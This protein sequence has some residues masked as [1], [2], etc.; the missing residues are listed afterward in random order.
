MNTGREMI[1]VTTKAWA[2]SM[3][4]EEYRALLNRLL[5]AERAGAKLL[6]AYL[7][8]LPA[9]SPRWQVLHAVQA[10][11][12][13]NCAALIRL[14]VGEEFHPSLS[15]G[16]FFP[17][18]LAIEDWRER[19]EYLNGGQV[20]VAETIAAALPRVQQSGRADLGKMLDSHLKNIEKCKFLE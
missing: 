18:G 2:A 7:N 6:S 15:V 19:L 14:L 5:E 1:A 8:G 11:E 4:P 17:K 10:D 13:L 16:D 12:A 20:W 3:G 9:G